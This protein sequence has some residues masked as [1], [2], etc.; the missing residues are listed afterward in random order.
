MST[1][2]LTRT[3]VSTEAVL[4][5]VRREHHLEVVRLT[6]VDGG[7]DISAR[8]L[9]AVDV[10]SRAYAIK[11]TRSVSPATLLVTRYL[12]DRGIDGATAPLPARDGRPWFDL[13]GLQV[14]VTP[15]INGRPAYTVDMT[16]GHWRA[17]GELLARV[18]TTR[19]PCDLDSLLPRETHH[20]PG[21]ATV[22]SIASEAAGVRL[23][24]VDELTAALLELFEAH[25]DEITTILH[26]IDVIGARLRSQP[27][28]PVLCHGDAHAANLLLAEDDSLNLIDWDGAVIAPRERD[29]MFVLGGVIATAPISARQQEWFLDGY[30]DV[31]VDPLRLAYYLCSWA[32]QDFAAYGAEV[33]DRTNDPAARRHALTMLRKQVSSTGIAR[34]A[35]Y[36]LQ[37]IDD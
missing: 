16:E 4:D 23:R 3:S 32:V 9:R 18:H 15:W 24:P 2:R 11:I 28:I 35:L 10:D 8:V 22:R 37:R 26:A 25:R 5:A 14:T 29:L 27:M 20:V 6:D 1:W 34:T 17:Y 7:E 21:R 33:R 12:V 30:G 36:A 13:G 31:E 19:L